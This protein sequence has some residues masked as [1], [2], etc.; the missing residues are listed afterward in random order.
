MGMEPEVQDFLKR[1][2]NSLSMALI[3]MMANM[4]AGIKYNL[5]FF[6]KYPT[7]KNYIYYAA[8]LI[9]LFF[10]IRYLIKKWRI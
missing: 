5:A 4:V 9:S 2:V 3:W 1:I 8:A 10:L 7:W 6:D